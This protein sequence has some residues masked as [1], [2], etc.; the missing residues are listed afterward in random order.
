LPFNLLD[1]LAVEYDPRAVWLQDLMR[2]RGWDSWTRLERL[3]P[4]D[5]PPAAPPSDCCPPAISAAEQLM[6]RK[7]NN[8]SRGPEG[9]S[10]QPVLTCGFT[11]ERVTGIEPALSAW[12][13]VPSRLITW[14]DLR[15]RVSA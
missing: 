9:E 14:P 13:S 4:P 8:S 5:Y 12:E 3:K 11:V 6:A 1:A 10:F 15:S 7:I 2:E